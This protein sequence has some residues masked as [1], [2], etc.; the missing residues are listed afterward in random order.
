MI[1]RLRSTR[2]MVEHL[3]AAHQRCGFNSRCAMTAD[4][5]ANALGDARREGRGWR[6][7]CP[8]HGGRSLVLRD[9]H[10]GRVLVTCW[11][12]CDRFAVLAELRRCGLMAG[13]RDFTPRFVSSSYRVDDAK[14]A[15]RA[16]NIWH[17]ASDG[18]NTIVRRYL[19]TRGIM[20]GHWPTS[21]RFHARCPRPT[22]DEGNFHQP[23]PAMVGLV[24]HVLRGGVAVHCTYLREDGSGKA[25]LEEPKATFGPVGG[26]AVRFGWPSA[27]GPFAVAEGT[28]T[29]L[30]VALACSIPVWAALSAGGIKKL[31]LPPEA[32]NVVICADHDA[33][34]TGQY[35][36]H[37]AAARWL[38]EGRRVR[39]ALPPRCDSDFNDV[40]IDRADTKVHEARHVD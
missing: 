38:A 11:G 13:G 9:G 27:D 7:R 12:G 24:Q 40:L 2:I 31:I 3:A 5:I 18:A 32:S 36:A 26:G 19:A 30:S 17:D 4:A 22:D 29:A 1:S 16:L 23:L 35:G 20:P 8:L 14:R 25:D 21:L 10:D 6:C 39:L 28:E 34:G 33:S 37:D 15:R